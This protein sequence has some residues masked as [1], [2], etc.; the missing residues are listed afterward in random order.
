MWGQEMGKV[1]GDS[2]VFSFSV[3]R[4]TLHQVISGKKWE[5]QLWEDQEHSFEHVGFQMSTRC[6]CGGACQTVRCV[7]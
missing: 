3:N 5:E 2:T 7:S 4:T 6:L 1:K